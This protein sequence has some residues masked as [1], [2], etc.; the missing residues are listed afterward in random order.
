M[1]ST[2]FAYALPETIGNWEGDM[3]GWTAQNGAAAVPGLTNGVTLDN[4]SLG[5][6]PT[7][8]WCQAMFKEW[9]GWWQETPFTGATKLTFDITMIASEWVLAEG[10]WVQPL[11]SI[12]LQGPDNWWKQYSHQVDWNPSQGDMTFHVEINL[13]GIGIA[14]Q[15]QRMIYVPNSSAAMTQQGV[16][17]LDNMVISTPEPATM[18]LLGLGGLA[19][20]RRKK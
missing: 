9:G 15:F 7:A 19:L 1:A 5:L 4:A 16:I 12:I 11:E 3:D 13:A 18:A 6:I 10:E 8:G 17:Y 2:S 14:T 20:I